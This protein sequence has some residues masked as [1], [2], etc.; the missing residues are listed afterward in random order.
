METDERN[1]VRAAAGLPFLDVRAEARRLQSVRNQAALKREWERR[2]PGFAPWIEAGD[3]FLSK[4]GRNSI[5]RQ[6]VRKQMLEHH[7]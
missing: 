2:T 4:M 5:A 7:D 6:R 3:G 1:A